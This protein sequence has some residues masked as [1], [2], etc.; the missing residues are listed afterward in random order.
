[1]VD[2]PEFRRTAVGLDLSLTASGV[3]VI[4]R[5]GIEPSHLQ[6]ARVGADG[7]TNMPVAQQIDAIR[8]L[9]DRVDAK[10]DLRARD[11]PVVAVVEALENG[12]TYGGATERT[13]LWWEVV[14][15]LSGMTVYMPTSAQV[16]IYATGNGRA[17]KKEVIA[18]VKQ[19]WPWWAVGDDDNLADAAVM[20]EIG[21]AFADEPSANLPAT[22]TRVLSKIRKITDPPARVANRKAKQR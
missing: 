10:L 15:R 22:H 20:A 6:L 3:A 4:R 2:E 19:H 13:V 12:Y 8:Q 14:T 7:I 9:A 16:K 21:I 5:V 1:M 18:A 17:S 11:V